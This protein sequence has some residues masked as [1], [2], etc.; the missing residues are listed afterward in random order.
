[1]ITIFYGYQRKDG[2]FSREGTGELIN[3]DNTTIFYVVKDAPGV[4]GDMT[5]KAKI[6]TKNLHIY[7]AQTL[8]ELDKKPVVL[9]IDPS[10]DPANPRVTDIYLLSA[11]G[12]TAATGKDK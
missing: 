3:Y 11:L 2:S 10:S 8:D 12:G 4:V 1:M 5:G 6:S 7:G 9:G